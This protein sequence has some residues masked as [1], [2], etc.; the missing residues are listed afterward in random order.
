MITSILVERLQLLTYFP[1]S[2]ICPSG[3]S[4]LM[5]E[6]ELPDVGWSNS[7]SSPEFWFH[8]TNRTEVGFQRVAW[9]HLSHQ[10][11]FLAWIPGER[12][13]QVYM[14]TGPGQVSSLFW[15][16]HKDLSRETVSYV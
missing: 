7:P 11:R 1:E 9:A 10:G 4:H 5:A 12:V 6:L 2:C 3:S 8:F 13:C 16:N 15:E 14:A